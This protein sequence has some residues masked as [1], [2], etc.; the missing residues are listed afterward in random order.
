ME[1]TF[2]TFNF[3]RWLC[4]SWICGRWLCGR[5][6]RGVLAFLGISAL[7]AF[8]NAVV[9]FAGVASCGLLSFCGRLFIWALEFFCHLKMTSAFC[10]RWLCGL[11][12]CGIWLFCHL[13]MTSAFGI[14]KKKKK[15]KKRF[16]WCLRILSYSGSWFEI[17][18]I[19]DPPWN[20]SELTGEA[21]SSDV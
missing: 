20:S 15:K 12:I 17:P 10:G 18:L 16:I 4:G 5:W 7:S 19:R 11:W 3:R 9:S 21:Q 2:W 1:S 13:T 14:L 6:L 8:F